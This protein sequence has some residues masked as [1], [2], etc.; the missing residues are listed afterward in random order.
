MYATSIH[1]DAGGIPG[2][3]LRVKDPVL[4]WLGC[5]PAVVALTRPLAWEPP[6]AAGPALKKAKEKKKNKRKEEE[7]RKRKRRKK[8]ETPALETR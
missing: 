8:R 5:R 3:A 7:K 1:E 4:L 6:Y 2:L